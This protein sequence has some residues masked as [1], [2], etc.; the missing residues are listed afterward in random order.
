M[1]KYDIIVIGTG[2]GGQKAAI[3]A[4]KLGKT[5]AIIEKEK[6]V[7]GAQVNTGTIPSKT[8]REASLYLSGYSKKNFYGEAYRVKQNITIADLVKF[9]E[10][11]KENELNVIRDAF[12]RNNIDLYWGHA[13]FVDS[14][15]IEVHNE[16]VKETLKA[17]KFVI[18]VGT[19]PARP[20][21]ID[22]T[23][24]NIYCSDSILEMKRLPKSM[25]IV[26]GGVIGSEY[27]CILSTLGMRITLIEGRSQLL[28][29]L[30]PEIAEA[31]QYHLR[32][33]GVTLRL[34]EKVETIKVIQEE[35]PSVVEAVLESGKKIRASSLL[36]SVG[37]RGV[38]GKLKL[39]NVGVEYDDREKL[40]VNK[41]YQTNKKHIYAVGDVIGF[42]ALA[43]TSME[44]G[45]LA[46][47]HAFGEPTNSIPELFPYGIYTVPE[48]S[49]VGKTEKELTEEE[50]PYETGK[51]QYEEIARGQ[52]IGD[53]IGMLK[54]IIHQ[55]TLQI[56]G[57]HAIGTGATELVHIGQA[58]MAFGGTVDYF[59]NNVFNFPTLAEAYK[60]AALNGK[61]KI[62]MI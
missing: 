7:G 19:V 59:I 17:D 56:L 39:E 30:D 58:V 52:I 20:E 48:I 16:N 36:Y 27:A 18:A 61:N 32:K 57:I 53:D 50:V 31:F 45:R 22:F 23:S 4:A 25:I 51:A 9:S 62:K 41:N 43:S 29:F 13:S 2:P 5:V 38:C 14:K 10:K 54:L 40:S 37:R 6:A 1:Q 49:M 21:N 55:E 46:A 35:A 60:I 3:Q 42:P 47:C 34:G 15:T 11:V 44:Q 8:L 24:N 28:G 12:E 33:T 26:G